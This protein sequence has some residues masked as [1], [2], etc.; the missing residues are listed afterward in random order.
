MNSLD[1]LEQLLRKR[2]PL[3]AAQI[4]IQTGCCKPTAYQRVEA[5]R[6]RGVEIFE[7]KQPELRPG[8]VATS[9]GIR[10]S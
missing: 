9:Y 10:S 5:L 3:T 4:A 7:V 8:P 6:A 2:G 1:H